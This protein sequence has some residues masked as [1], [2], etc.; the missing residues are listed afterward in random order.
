MFISVWD[1]RNGESYTFIDLH[2]S[3]ALALLDMVA[4]GTGFLIADASREL[5]PKIPARIRTSWYIRD[6]P[7]EG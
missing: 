4:S 5:A 7:E 6:L 1:M 2:P 3:H